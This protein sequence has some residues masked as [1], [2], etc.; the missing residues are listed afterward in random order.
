MN[1]DDG[2]SVADFILGLWNGGGTY[3]A[4]PETGHTND[5]AAPYVHHED[6]AFKSCPGCRK[7]GWA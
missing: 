2:M 1:D 7:E 5:G 3:M 6:N 4:H